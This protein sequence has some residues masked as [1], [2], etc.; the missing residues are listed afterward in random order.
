MDHPD[1]FLVDFAF[2]D[3]SVVPAGESNPTMTV[4]LTPR[5]AFIIGNP[6]LACL[7]V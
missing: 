2:Y 4:L 5:V 3:T 6:A 1:V 7:A